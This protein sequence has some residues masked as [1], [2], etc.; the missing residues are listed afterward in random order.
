VRW[1]ELVYPR[2]RAD[3]V[4]SAH[5]A[6]EENRFT[7]ERE[8]LRCYLVVCV[9]P[10]CLGLYGQASKR[11]WWMPRRQEAMKDVVACEKPRGAGKQALIRG[12][13][14]GETRPPRGG[15]PYLNT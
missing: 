10:E 12:C 4:F 15:H 13:P 14:N 3:E 6:F 1:C 5:V 2:V 9:T 11:V 8:L 7:R